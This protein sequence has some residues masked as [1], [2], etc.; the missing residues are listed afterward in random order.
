MD[1][2]L[3]REFITLPTVD[4]ER[5]GDRIVITAHKTGQQ[6]VIAAT[7]FEAAALDGWCISLLEQARA[8]DDEREA[9][10]AACDALVHAYDHGGNKYRRPAHAEHCA[11]VIRARALQK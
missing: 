1:K 4:I 5:R 2:Y 10:A 3:P 7:E 8:I 11:A 9:C 6:A